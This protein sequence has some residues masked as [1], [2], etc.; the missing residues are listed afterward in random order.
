MEVIRINRRGFTLLEL[1]TATT[2]G[3]MASLLLA[4]TSLMAT[5]TFKKVSEIS[6]MH[7]FGRR[8]FDQFVA[9]VQKAELSLTQFPTNSVN[10]WF[11]AKDNDCVIL[12]QPVFLADNTVDP[13]NSKVVVYRLIP[14][15][16]A[17][18]GPYVL[19]RTV[20]SIAI[21]G[22]VVSS[23]SGTKV[24]VAKNIKSVNW[25][26]MTS[27]TFWGD[28]SSKVYTLTS[29]PAADTNEIKLQALIGGVNR[30]Q[31]GHAV[32]A[33]KTVT[34]FQAMEYGV[35]MDV[36]YHIDPTTVAFNNGSNGATSIYTKIV[37]QPRWTANDLSIKTRDISLSAMPNLENKVD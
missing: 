11:K 33:G 27:Q 36:T 37:F 4:Q 21:N 23:K 31:S 17:D 19:E 7:T 6:R 16:K 20:G 30:L 26:Q 5:K 28:R 14:A 8:T 13:N 3:L 29:T 34:L 32:L 2:I 9:D 12:R 18:E 35:A 10:P 22:L 1:M 15:L 25:N 24:V